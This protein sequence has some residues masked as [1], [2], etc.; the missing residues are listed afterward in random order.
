LP[1]KISDGVFWVGVLD[2]KLRVFHGIA[3]P[4]GGTYNSY[5]I[6]GGKS[7]LIDTVYEPFFEDIKRN[8]LR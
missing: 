7:A 5:L 1:I 4:K 8:L 3:T 6:V 2:W